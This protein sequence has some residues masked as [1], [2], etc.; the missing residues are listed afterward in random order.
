LL[1]ARLESAIASWQAAENASRA[2]S[3]AVDE[4]RRR[5]RAAEAGATIDAVSFAEDDLFAA[6]ERALEARADVMQL[7][8]W[9]Q[10]L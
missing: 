10:R 8:A 4:M 3:V 6:T 2:A 1:H 7:C 9:I 5:Y